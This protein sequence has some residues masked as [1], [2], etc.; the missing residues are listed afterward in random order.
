MS[1]KASSK[2]DD[3]VTFKKGDVIRTNPEKGF[4]GIAVVLDDGH[5]IEVEPGRLSGPMCHIATTPLLFRHEVTMEEI[6]LEDLR[7]MLFQRCFALKNKSIVYREELLVHIYTTRNVA[8]FPIIGSV[9]P[10]IVYNEELSWMPG[11]SLIPV[12]FHWCGHAESSWFG[13]EPYIQ[14]LREKEGQSCSD[15]E[16]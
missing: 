12:R 8:N 10:S 9:D 2:N 14:W 1:K 5:Q 6:C 11:G 3:M 13:R 7:P 16:R 4:Y 15:N